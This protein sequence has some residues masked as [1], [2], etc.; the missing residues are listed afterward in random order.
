MAASGTSVAI[1]VTIG[2]LAAVTIIAWIVSDRRRKRTRALAIYIKE[3]TPEFW[4]ALP[5]HARHL[6]VVGAVERFRRDHNDRSEPLPADFAELYEGKRR[7][8]RFEAV[9]LALA[10]GLILMLIVGIKYLGWQFAPI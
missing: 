4:D 6:N 7:H 9:L 2:L 10:A 1:M 8:A 3:Q 5:W